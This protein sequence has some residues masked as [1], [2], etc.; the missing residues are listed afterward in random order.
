MCRTFIYDTML[1]PVSFTDPKY[2]FIR[3]TPAKL[4]I[5]MP[6]LYHLL[7]LT[8]VRDWYPAIMDEID[9]EVHHIMNQLV[10]VGVIS[11]KAGENWGKYNKDWFNQKMDTIHMSL[12]LFHYEHTIARLSRT[13][14]YIPEFDACYST[15]SSRV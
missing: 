2:P 9:S 7:D 14:G 4:A 3:L 1:A 15:T 13:S 12:S 5:L 11:L 6:S 10:D 8:E